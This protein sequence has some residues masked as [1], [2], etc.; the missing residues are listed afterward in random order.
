MPKGP[1]SM[2]IFS[3]FHLPRMVWCCVL[4]LCLCYGQAGLAEPLKDWQLGFQEASSPVMEK[5]DWLHN[6]VLIIITAITVFVTG[7]L[8]YVMIRFRRSAN[9]NPSKTTHNVL[10]EIIWTAVPVLILIAIVVPSFRLLYFMDRHPNPE[11][12]LKVIGYQ[13]YWGYEYPDHG[14]FAFDS[15]MIPDEE[16]KEGQVRLL[17]VDNRV[18]LPVDTDIRILITAADVIHAWAL[19]ALGVKIDAV[20]GRTN[21]TWVRID[22]PGIYRGQCSE[23]CG[24]YHGFMP[25][26][27]E[28]VSKEEFERWTKEAAE[29]FAAITPIQTTPRQKEAPFITLATRAPVSLSF[30]N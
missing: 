23:L 4:T 6:Y 2:S 17:E 26:V 12:T 3:S 22:E 15:Y 24:A 10:I 7:L 9:P 1:H 5:I 25:V 30:A 19:P 20:P 21:E 18:V 27:I 16:I 8:V 13:W 28:A 14:D 11:M 29:K